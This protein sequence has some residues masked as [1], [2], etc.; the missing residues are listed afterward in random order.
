MKCLRHLVLAFLICAAP[1]FAGEIRVCSWN[2]C[3]FGYNRTSAPPTDVDALAG[4]LSEVQPDLVLIQ[5]VRNND[6]GHDAVGALCAAMNELLPDDAEQYVFDTAGG[7]GH[8]GRSSPERLG[9]IWRPP[10][11]HVGD[12][13]EYPPLD[14]ADRA[15]WF[16]R[17]PVIGRFTVGDFSL[18]VMNLHLDTEMSETTIGHDRTPGRVM[19]YIGLR[20]WLLQE[21]DGHRLIAGDFNRHLG[22]TAAETMWAELMG[23]ADMRAYWRFPLLEA[24]GGDLL[25]TRSDREEHSTTITQGSDDV[26]DQF[27]VGA[28]LWS[29]VEIAWEDG[30]DWGTD[31]TADLGVLDFDNRDPWR[32][33]HYQQLKYT[34]SDHRPIWIDLRTDLD[35][36]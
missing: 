25:T 4:I 19:E 5:E 3:Q 6:D 28:A 9:F 12:F 26:Y 20:K 32:L 17:R 27:M 7:G 14:N 36:T 18:S 29:A 8:A 21:G 31:R 30:I 24:M 33:M 35:D 11:E 34:I 2:I 15:W 10:V 1:T 22:G 13:E 23:R 16:M